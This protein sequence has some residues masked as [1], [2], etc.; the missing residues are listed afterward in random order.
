[1]SAEDLANTILGVAHIAPKRFASSFDRSIVLLLL[2]FAAPL[3]PCSSAIG[4][5]PAGLEGRLVAEFDL[6]RFGS[7]TVGLARSMGQARATKRDPS[8]WSEIFVTFS[9]MK[10]TDVR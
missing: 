5:D 4:A 8:R 10:R 1:M 7:G 6:G 3:S 2:P 9:G